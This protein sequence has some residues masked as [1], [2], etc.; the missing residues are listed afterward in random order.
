MLRHRQN[1]PIVVGRLVRDAAYESLLNQNRRRIHHRVAERLAAGA[2]AEPE[3]IGQHFYDA[4]DWEQAVEFWRQAGGNAIAVGATQEAT[5]HLDAALVALGHC[6]AGDERDRVELEIL[7]DFAPA[8]MTVRGYAAARPKELYDRAFEVA[9]TVGDETQRFTALWGGYYI[10]EVRGDWKQSAANID[11]LLKLDTGALR[12]DL[13]LQIDHAATSFFTNIGQVERGVGHAQRVIDAYDLE[14]HSSH[15]RLFAGHD[16]AVC[17]M[18]QMAFLLPES[19]RPDRAY[20]VAEQARQL[21]AILDHP[22]STALGQW[23]NVWMLMV[24]GDV[25]A[26]RTAIAEWMQYCTEQRVSAILKMAEF[27]ELAVS[28][29]RAAAHAGLRA[30]IDPMRERERRALLLPEY[31]NFCAEA[32]IDVGEIEHALLTLD[33]S[34]R[35]AESTGEIWRLGQTHYLRGEALRA[36]GERDLKDAIDAFRTGIQFCET[37][38]HQWTRLKLATSLAELLHET[39]DT[40]QARTTLTPAFQ[41]FSEGHHTPL[42]RRARAIRDQLH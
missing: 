20:E 4:Q 33:Y 14:V 15:K 29:D 35:A 17:A 24:L 37:T 9:A 22:P 28:P 39:G 19:G 8:A 21:A 2:G 1:P 18:G 6:H 11:H 42:L 34:Q 40:Q 36:G 38:G 7:L 27:Y 30:R 12:R 10:T 23:M 41:A 26:A 31:A 13:P 5:A 25:T 32:A 16:P 3:L